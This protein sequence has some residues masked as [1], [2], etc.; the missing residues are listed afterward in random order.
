MCFLTRSF[1][2]QQLQGT[3]KIINR[4]RTGA[5]PS[6]I[7]KEICKT[8]VGQRGFW[9]EQKRV[10]KLKSKKPVPKRLADTIPLDSFRPLLDK[11]YA[12]EHKSNAR[13][14][15]ITHKPPQP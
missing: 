3:S 14:N 10:A 6:S 1:S 11:G 7:G 13:R 8:T 9:D 4:L 2:G 15:L 12:Q 5:I